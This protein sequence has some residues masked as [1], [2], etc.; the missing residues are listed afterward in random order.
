MKREE[1]M[2][3]IRG[4]QTFQMDALALARQLIGYS[5]ILIDLGT[6]DGRFVQHMA[7][8]RSD[9]F[10]IGVDACRENLRALSRIA[11]PNALY[12][13]A[14]AQALPCELYRLASHVTINFPWGSLLS[15]LLAG[16]PMLLAG[17]DAIAQLGTTL[18]VRLN[19][20]AL[21]EAGWSLEDGTERVRQVL[22]ANGFAVKQHVELDALELRACPTTW[23]KRLAFGR[24]PRAQYLHGKRV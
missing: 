5:Q 21:A 13:I 14:N 24:D 23:A 3:I 10:A 1:V 22:S 4:K 12:V 20:G 7:Q 8:A 19:G 9:Q 15:G 18:D 16:D 2:E 11:L 6:G 17:L